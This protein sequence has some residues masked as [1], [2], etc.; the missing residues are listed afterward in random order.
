MVE[1]NFNH[2]RY[3]WAVVREGGVSAAS[4]ALNVSQPTVSAQLRKL[5]AAAGE[6]LFHRSG[7]SLVLTDTGRLVYRYA[8]EIFDLGSELEGVLAGRPASIQGRLRVGLADVVP[9]LIAHRILRPAIPDAGSDVHL[10]CF[11]GKPRE[12]FAQLATYALDA[13]ISDV[14][15][16]PQHNIRAFNHLLGES[17]VTF[18]ACGPLAAELRPAFPESLHQ[19]PAL[20][21][22]PNTAIRRELD[23][24]YTA[25]GMQPDV[26]GEFED[27]ALQKVF[28]HDGLGVFTA[29]S[30]IEAEVIQQYGAEVIGRTDEVRERFYV[31]SVERRVRNEAVAAIVESA[32]RDLFD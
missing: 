25:K 29:P 12:L 6:P 26:V 15:V 28:G 23:R 17:G 24:W 16:E 14:P 7:R 27:S 5:E 31:I 21:P 32:R 8:E 22:T 10:A 3:L 19:A 9:K 13:V 20:M 18:F 11:E 4:R 2:L 1:L 30:V